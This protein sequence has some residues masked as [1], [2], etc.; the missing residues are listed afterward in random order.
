MKY[1]VFLPKTNFLAKIK[2]SER[3]TLD[4][5]LTFDGDLHGFYKWQ[6]ARQGNLKE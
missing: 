4:T 3:S 5:K 1:P 2:S 6:N